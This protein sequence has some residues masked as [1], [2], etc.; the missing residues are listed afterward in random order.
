MSDF[1]SY[2]SARIQRI[3]R[4]L[5]DLLPRLLLTTIHHSPLKR[6]H[7]VLRYSVLGAGKRLR[8]LLVYAVGESLN[9][10]L[11]SLDAMAAAV[12]LIH[13]YSLIHDDLPA[14]DNDDLRR[15]KPT[16][17]KAFDEPTAILAG[18]ALQCLAF[19]IL[20]DAKLNPVAAEQQI[21]MIRCLAQ[22]SGRQGMVQGQV[23]DM[24]YS[25]DPSGE[26]A[27]LDLKT[28]CKI[29][30]KKTGALIEAAVLGG[31]FGTPYYSQYA[32]PLKKYARY[33]GL[34]FQIQDDI[35]DVI[36]SSES[37]GKKTQKDAAH[38]KPTFVSQMGLEKAQDL[39]GK[40]RIK[41]LDSIRDLKTEKTILKDL[42]LFFIR[43]FKNSIFS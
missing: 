26:Q 6:F 9:Q 30:L 4:V 18:D 15:G 5:E 33:L 24:G 27:V 29:P 28:L 40:L 35:L 8:P 10:P 38:N 37:L 14:M 16:T 25:I 17:H 43:D 21:A 32:Q 39:V 42:V 3:E 31:L 36:E 20:S 23:L 12:E 13:C 19:E 1:Q 7:E 41:A 2:Y 22:K 11:T 34:C